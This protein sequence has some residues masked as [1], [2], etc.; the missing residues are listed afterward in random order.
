M[1]Q[2]YPVNHLDVYDTDERCADERPQNGSP[3]QADVV[4]AG[5]QID[6]VACANC[7]DT[8]QRQHP[9][10][11]R[12]KIIYGGKTHRRNS[13]GDGIHPIWMVRR[14][15][16][17]FHKIVNAAHTDSQYNAKRHCRNNQHRID[18]PH[19]AHLNIIVE[20]IVYKVDDGNAGHKKQCA[21]HQRMPRCTGLQY[22]SHPLRHIRYKS[23][24]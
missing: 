3:I 9:K 4:V 6:K 13:C 10:L 18:A 22:R 1:R 17:V 5:S 15:T 24:G 23:R 11:F 2:M 16:Q 19:D 14:H 12:W 20:H 8:T 7:H 21:C